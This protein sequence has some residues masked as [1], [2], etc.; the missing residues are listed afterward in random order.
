M[1][2]RLHAYCQQ[3]VF[4]TLLLAA[5]ASPQHVVMPEGCTAPRVFASVPG[6]VPICSDYDE[7]GAFSEIDPSS[8]AVMQQ[9]M[10]DFWHGQ[11]AAGHD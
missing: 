6:Y 2:S 4:L 5:C 8:Y 3:A 11:N 10:A 9:R 7:G 1:Q